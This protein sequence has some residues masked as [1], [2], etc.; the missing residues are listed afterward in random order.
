L[1]D[2]A[3][4]KIEREATESLI[5]RGIG[6]APGITVGPAYIVGTDGL[7]VPEYQLAAAQVGAELDRFRLAV[8]QAQKQLRQLQHRA[9]G[10]PTAAADEIRILLDAHHA[11]LTGSRLIRGVE[12]MIRTQRLNAEAAIERQIKAISAGFAAMAD[13]YLAARI[14][15]IREVGQRLLRHLLQQH[16]NPFAS[17]PDGCVLFA[18]EITPADTAL[19]DP[20]R[21]AGFVAALGGAEGHAAIMARALGLP[22][23]LGVG[24]L[25]RGLANNEIVIVDGARGEI[26]I[27]PTAAQLRLARQKLRQQTLERER[28]KQLRRLPSVTQDGTAIALLANLELPRELSTALEVGAQGIGLLRT[29]FMFMNRSDLPGED[30]QFEALRTMV[31]G[32][33]GKPMTVRTLDIGGEKLAGALGQNSSSANPALGLRAIRLSLKMPKLLETQL[34]AILR[35]AAC[36]PIKILVPMISS[37]SQM[38]EVRQIMQQVAKRLQ[39]RGVEVPDPLPPLGAMIEIPAAALTA[40]SLAQVSDFFAIGSNDLTQ[41]TLAIDRG[42]EQVAELYNPLHPA[43]LRLLQFTT[44]AALRARIPVSLC[45]EMA[46]EPA[47]TALLIGLGLRDFSMSPARLPLVKAEIRQLDLA[48]ANALAE[49]IMA[50]S[51]EATLTR[52]VHASHSR[53]G[54]RKG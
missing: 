48:R 51:D 31:L 7:S 26:I 8:Q 35:A 22:A 12:D 38:R 23:V 54:K 27:R 2:A 52:L 21:V 40:D 44:G 43:V 45:G 16:H 24:A 13:R 5:L 41:Y 53:G 4:M 17:A 39:R 1:S 37:V 30:E 10:L 3:L 34:A 11:M 29:E 28:L 19:M 15:D 49:Q 47:Y 36:G 9:D 32:L 6:V 14:A 20:A 46:G 42:D 25:P 18:E 50:Q 33:K